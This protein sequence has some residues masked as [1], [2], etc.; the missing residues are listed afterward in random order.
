[1]NLAYQ[2]PEGF[3]CKK[4]AMGVFQFGGKG[5]KMRQSHKQEIAIMK[6]NKEEKRARLKAKA[7][8]LIEAYLAWEEQ[9][10]RPDL[11]EIEEIA[12]KLRKE[13]GREIAQ[14]AVEEQAERAPVP[15]PSCPRC[16]K[17]M[18]Y[19]G[20]KRIEVESRV[21][22]LQI[23]RGYYHCPECRERIFPPRSTTEDE[24]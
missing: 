5:E 8:E 16:G 18:V 22:G 2:A 6:K 7:E 10:A 11:T 20:E 15:G 19:K 23:E 4:H 3:L 24:G 12:L 21:G 13:L 17:E 14:M 1:M 9:H